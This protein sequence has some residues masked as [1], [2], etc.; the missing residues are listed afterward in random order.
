MKIKPN[1]ER[2]AH[3]AL[4][5]TALVSKF[6]KTPPKTGS[7]TIF[8]L[9]L[10]PLAEVSASQ[11]PLRFVW[12]SF[13]TAEGGRENQHHQNKLPT[14]NRRGRAG[15]GEARLTAALPAMAAAP[16]SCPFCGLVVPPDTAVP[17]VSPPFHCPGA[18]GTPGTAIRRWH[19][20]PQQLRQSGLHRPITAHQAGEAASCLPVPKP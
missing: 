1:D 18:R 8:S 5:A 12:V 4:N 6:T 15:R 11:L 14:H 10:C 19:S 20:R 3:W 9:V 7:F 2:E 16:Q 13:S 17:T